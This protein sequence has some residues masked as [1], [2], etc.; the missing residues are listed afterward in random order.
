LSKYE[1]YSVSQQNN[2]LSQ[3]LSKP[4]KTMIAGLIAVSAQIANATTCQVTESSSSQSMIFDRIASI[5][6]LDIS[7]KTEFLLKKN[8]LNVTVHKSSNNNYQITVFNIKPGQSAG[9]V[10]S[11]VT[12]PSLPISLVDG[13]ANLSVYCY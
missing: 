7:E 3:K 6:V 11:I 4:R 5:S 8:E 12:A 1:A 9:E 2:N 13:K 10:L